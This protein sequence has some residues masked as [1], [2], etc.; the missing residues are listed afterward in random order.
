MTGTSVCYTPT[1]HVGGHWE[2]P[3][4]DASAGSDAKAIGETGV[5]V[6]ERKGCL[7]LQEVGLNLLWGWGWG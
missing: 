2:N 6:P 4:A 5:A 7:W 1:V 3:A